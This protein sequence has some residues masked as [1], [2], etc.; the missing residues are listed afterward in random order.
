M[1]QGAAW[2]VVFGLLIASV[3]AFEF[4]NVKKTNPGNNHQDDEASW[5]HATSCPPV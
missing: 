5:P 2:F 1:K 4:S 3:S